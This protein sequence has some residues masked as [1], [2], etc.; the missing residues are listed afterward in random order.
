MLLCPI[1]GIYPLTLVHAEVNL[2]IALGTCALDS[3]LNTRGVAA[4]EL[5]RDE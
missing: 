4:L 3:V 2:I 5:D 1:A